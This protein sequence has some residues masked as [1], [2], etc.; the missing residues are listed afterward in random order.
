K[1]L[2]RVR[3]IEVQILGDLEG[4]LVHLYER[5][6]SVQRR[7]QKVIEIAPAPN[8]SPQLREQIC[9]DALKLARASHYTSAG[10]A[11]FLV[12]GGNHYFIEVNARLQV[13]HTVTEQITGIDLVHAQLRIAEGHA[14]RSS[15]IGIIDQSSVKPRGFA[16]QCRVTTEDPANNFLP[17]TGYIHTWRIGSGFGGRLDAGNGYTGAYMCPRY[18]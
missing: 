14:L 15:A 7:H 11:E 9:E 8:L 1:Y 6:C 13:E 12:S 2:E 10:T 16:V 17:D 3:H 18:R 4:N 5:D